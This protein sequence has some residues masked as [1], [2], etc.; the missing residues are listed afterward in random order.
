M[1]E[2]STIG[3]LLRIVDLQKTTEV[4]TDSFWAFFSYMG[5][6][7]LIN[8][9]VAEIGDYHKQYSR[10]TKDSPRHKKENKGC[11]ECD[12]H[13]SIFHERSPKLCGV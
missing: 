6:F 12:L 3:V 2:Q 1:G 10:L 9:K 5:V 4:P 13:C 8:Y 11:L 7:E